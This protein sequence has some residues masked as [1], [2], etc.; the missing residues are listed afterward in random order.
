MATVEEKEQEYRDYI[1]THK[2]N[3]KRAYWKLVRNYAE[4]YLSPQS[5]EILD[6]N[7][8]HHDEDKDIDFIFHAYRKNHFPVD[9]K[10]KE[11]SQEEYEIAWDYHKKINPHHWEF[12][13]DD[14]DEEFTN[15]ELMEEEIEIYKIAYLEMLSDW[16]SFTF[17]IAR[18]EIGK[19]DGISTKGDSIEFESWYNKNKDKIKIHPQLQDWFNSLVQDII[20]KLNND[21]SVLYEGVI[22]REKYHED[23]NTFLIQSDKGF[24]I[25]NPKAIT[26]KIVFDYEE[27]TLFDDRYE[28]RLILKKLLEKYKKVLKA[29]R[30]S[31]IAEV[32]KDMEENPNRY[33]YKK[34]LE[35][36]EEERIENNIFN[37]DSTEI[38]QAIYN[39]NKDDTEDFSIYEN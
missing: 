33:N 29:V 17:K 15:P 26:F 31:S 27:A 18:E 13:L 34:E 1:D 32:E 7:I 16:L 10:E 36:A 14:N 11:T 25:I 38:S 12:F 28:A 22:R 39:S 30:V 21:N 5:L 8:D 4:E 20:E 24:L 23:N 37:S 3:V 19:G 35:M 9:E 2:E 6:R